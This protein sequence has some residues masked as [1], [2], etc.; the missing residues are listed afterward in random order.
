MNISR[1]IIVFFILVCVVLTFLVTLIAQNRIE[2]TM[3]LEESFIEKNMMKLQNILTSNHKYLSKISYEYATHD[4]LTPLVKQKNANAIEAFMYSKNDL[5]KN[6][7]LSHMVYFDVNKEYIFG[8]SYDLSSNEELSVAYEL[9]NFFQSH[10]ISPYLNN[11]KNHYMTLGFEK[12]SFEIEPILHNNETIGYVFLARALDSQFLTNIT[13]VLQEYVSLVSSY[14]NPESKIV[15]YFEQNIVYDIKRL[16]EDQIHSFMKLYDELSQRTFYIRLQGSR[17]VYQELVWELKYSLY[18]FIGLFLVMIMIFFVFM[19]RLFTSRIQYITQ[20]IK[21]A[22][23]NESVFCRLKIDYNDE[24]SYLSTKI[25]EMFASIHAHQDMTL[26]KERDFLQSVLD[27]QQNIILITD[28][29]SIHSTN[30]KF[31]EIFQSQESFLNNIAL[32][33]NRTKANLVAV[34]KRFENQEKVAKFQVVDESK[35]FTFDVSRLDIKKYLICMNDVSHFNKKIS[36]LEV[37]ASIDELTCIYNKSTITN[38]AQSWLQKRN[39]CLIIFDIDFFKKV[40]DKYGHYIGDCILKDLSLL[41][42]KEIPKDDIMGRFGGEEFLILINDLTSEN[43]L[44]IANRLRGI[45]QDK[46]FSYDELKVNVTISM[47]CTYCNINESFVDI[48]KRADKAL[49]EAKEG[50]RNRVVYH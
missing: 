1:K 44:N 40:N 50:G 15:K 31:Q 3:A 12:V 27:T 34:A 18:A 38:I 37:K 41:I 4:R 30:K 5:M 39:F 11:N 43:V 9:I 46:V 8:Q 35:Y 13:E 17:D 20:K 10:D 42:S 23:F 16:N 21:E 49:Y 32:L 29:K 25:N 48:Y 33:D 14:K 22:S 2:S 47:G 26:K 19:N 24:I 36:T 28:G 6:L 7:N 45:V